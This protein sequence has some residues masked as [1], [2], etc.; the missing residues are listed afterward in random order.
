MNEYAPALM[1][2]AVAL[3]LFAMLAYQM[4]TERKEA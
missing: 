2:L 1:A 4:W 3:V